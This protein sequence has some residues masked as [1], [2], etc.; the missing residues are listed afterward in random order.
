MVHIEM[1]KSFLTSQIP[2]ITNVLWCKWPH[3]ELLQSSFK[4]GSLLC[5]LSMGQCS[6][7]KCRLC[8]L[9]SW[10]K[11]TRCAFLFVVR[12]AS[13]HNFSFSAEGCSGMP[14]TLNPYRLHWCYELLDFCRVFFFPPSGM[15]MSYRGSLHF[16]LFWS[17]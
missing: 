5:H 11:P 1:S 9:Q 12:N 10:K 16:L 2:L 4:S 15:H 7:L 13:C 17:N 6:F 3:L 14:Q 8:F